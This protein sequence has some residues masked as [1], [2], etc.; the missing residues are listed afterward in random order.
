MGQR[1]FRRR[2]LHVYNSYPL[3]TLTAPK[4]GPNR[5][6]PM[7]E[8]VQK[9]LKVHRKTVPHGREAVAER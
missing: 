8:Q 3:G 4:S 2:G 6:V 7:A 9:L 1:R 5:T